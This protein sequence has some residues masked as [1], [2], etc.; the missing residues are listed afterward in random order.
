MIEYLGPNP[1]VR[2]G[3]G[4]QCG[5]YDLLAA[6]RYTTVLPDASIADLVGSVNSCSEGR[7]FG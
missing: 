6:L 2:S 1:L 3:L 4:E 5:Q 7:T